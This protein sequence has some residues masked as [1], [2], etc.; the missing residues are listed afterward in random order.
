LRAGVVFIE[1]SGAECDR[2]GGG[3]CDREVNAQISGVAVE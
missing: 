3:W 1:V 2:S